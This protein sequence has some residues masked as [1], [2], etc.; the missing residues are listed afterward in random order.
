MA[1]LLLTLSL[2]MM[3]LSSWANELD[4]MDNLLLALDTFS[5]SGERSPGNNDPQ[6]RSGLGEDPS[7]K[8]GYSSK[9]KDVSSDN[10]PRSPGI[11]KS[12]RSPGSEKYIITKK[13]QRKI[14]KRERLRIERE[15]LEREDVKKNTFSDYRDK[16]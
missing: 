7:R 11:D 4:N 1:K 5:T 16:L 8:P 13:K 12:Q 2:F 3:P 9:R 14:E 10:T 15:A 6:R